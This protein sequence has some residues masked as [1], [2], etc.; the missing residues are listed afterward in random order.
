MGLLDCATLSYRVP[1]AFESTFGFLHN[2]LSISLPSPAGLAGLC[3]LSAN[4]NLAP[5]SGDPLTSMLDCLAPEARVDVAFQI[6][7]CRAPSRRPDVL[8][9]WAQLFEIDPR[10]GE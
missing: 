9:M 7:R 2:H 5:N 10:V 4:A 3:V 8:S 6:T 1:P